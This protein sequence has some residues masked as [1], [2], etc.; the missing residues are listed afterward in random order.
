MTSSPS[1]STEAVIATKIVCHIVMRAHQ[2]LS[3][4]LQFYRLR[5]ELLI[6]LS[7]FLSAIRF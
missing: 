6:I 1:S 3:N 7:P 5:Q 4:I 2:V